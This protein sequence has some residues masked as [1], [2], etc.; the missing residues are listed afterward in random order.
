MLDHARIQG[1]WCIT[2]NLVEIGVISSRAW[3]DCG[4][5]SGEIEAQGTSGGRARG[6]PG[7]SAHVRLGCRERRLGARA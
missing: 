4:D 1:T 6:R 2:T 3:Y 5:A 7:G